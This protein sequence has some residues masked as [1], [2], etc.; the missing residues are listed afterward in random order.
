MA[1]D[2]IT[3]HG[4][5]VVPEHAKQ[6]RAFFHEMNQLGL[7]ACFGNSHM[8]L[9]EMIDFLKTLSPSEL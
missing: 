3:K 5:N 2:R 4:V 7:T 8:T 6:T 9:A 1:T